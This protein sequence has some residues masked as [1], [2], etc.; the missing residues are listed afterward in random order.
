MLEIRTKN[1]G[2]SEMHFSTVADPDSEHPALSRG[3]AVFVG[4]LP[5]LISACGL[6]PRMPI[7]TARVV[8]T[9]QY[10]QFF[11]IG[12]D[13]ASTSCSA[14]DRNYLSRMFPRLIGP[15]NWASLSVVFARPSICDELAAEQISILGN[16]LA[17]VY[18][19]PGSVDEFVLEGSGHYYLVR[20]ADRSIMMG[21]DFQIKPTT[22]SVADMQRGFLD[23]DIQ[24]ITTMIGGVN[25]YMHDADLRYRIFIDLSRSDNDV[26]A[27]DYA[28]RHQA[29]LGED[30]VSEMVFAAG[31]RPGKLIDFRGVGLLQTDY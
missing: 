24:L 17:V 21:G 25:T 8:Q 6:I 19:T 14:D 22:H 31:D 10:E 27:I 28:K 30:M 11:T 1:A 13:D 12:S 9:E 18:L 23:I 15:E 2:Y 7:Q 16:M 3:L 5:L 29:F 26:Y 20:K 4:L